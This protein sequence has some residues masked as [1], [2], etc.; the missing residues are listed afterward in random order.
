MKKLLQNKLFYLAVGVLI[1]ASI[2]VANYSSATYIP[3]QTPTS[4]FYTPTLTNV[5]NLSAST[6]YDAQWMRNGNVVTVGGRLD[7][8]PTIA[9][10]TALGISLPI[11]S[12]IAGLEGAVGT[13][14]GSSVASLTAA[15][16][17]DSTN[18]RA[19]M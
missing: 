11:P 4:G 15:V 12:N 7:V 10:P 17:G 18:D 16:V 9:G 14:N 19:Q 13:A 5:T 6:V 3:T 2:L 1:T 8:D